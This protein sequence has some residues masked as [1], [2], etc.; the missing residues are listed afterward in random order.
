MEN[1]SLRSFDLSQKNLTKWSRY[2]LD[3]DKIPFSD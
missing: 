1:F 3:D 2:M